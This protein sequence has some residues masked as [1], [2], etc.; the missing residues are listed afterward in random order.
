MSA[1][2]TTSAGAPDRG[3]KTRRPL[4]RATVFLARGLGLLL[5]FCALALGGG[6]F[7]LRTP[8]AEKFLLDKTAEALAA[9]GFIFTA[10]R[11][12]GPLPQRLALEDVSLADARGPILKAARAEVRWNMA[13]LLSGTVLV[14]IVE[15]DR[16]EMFRLPAPSPD[17][18]KEPPDSSRPFSPPVTIRLNALRLQGGRLHAAVLR[19]EAGPEG[20]V[21]ALTASGSAAVSSG[22]LAATLRC[23]ARL[24]EN[25][26]LSLDLRLVQGAA[27]QQPD[28][29]QHS[30]GS[31][32]PD[33]SQLHGGPERSDDSQ[34]PGN[35]QRP[36]GS[37]R[38]GGPEDTLVL[39]LAGDEAPGGILALVLD[40]PDLPAYSLRLNGSGGLK[41][42]RARLSLLA[43]KGETPLARSGARTDEPAEP[44]V[45]PDILDLSADLRLRCATGSLL[46]DV[47]VK[48]AFNLSLTARA[49][50]GE[51]I[52]PSLLPL[53]KGD[54]RADLEF[55]AAGTRYDL[56]AEA[57][58][59]AWSMRIS[60]AEIRPD[61]KTGL[62]TIKAAFQAV[63]SDPA[64]FTGGSGTAAS[65]KA[66]SD[67]NASGGNTHG[68]SADAG[69]SGGGANTNADGNTYGANA[70]A[71]GS[72]EAGSR[73]A[74]PLQ[75]AALTAA[76]EGSLG[77]DQSDLTL[78]GTLEAQTRER[79]FV[80]PCTLEAEVRERHFSLRR[81]SASGLGIRAEAAADFYA[82]SGAARATADIVADDKAEWQ[83]LVARLAGFTGP[84]SAETRT[85]EQQDAHAAA[86]GGELRLQASLNL[87]G[88]APAGE[89]TD[90]NPEKDT[91][92]AGKTNGKEPPA[93][94]NAGNNGA[95]DSAAGNNETV[96][97]AA[98]DKSRTSGTVATGNDRTGGSAG[99]ST[100]AD[101]ASPG[102]EM[103]AATPGIPPGSGLLRLTGSGM[104]WPTAQ[105]AGMLGPSLEVSARLKT[106]ENGANAW[107]VVLEEARAGIF[108]ASGKAVFTPP[109]G[110]TTASGPAREKSAPAHGASPRQTND[111]AGRQASDNTGGQTDSAP[112]P[113]TDDAARRQAEDKTGSAPDP[114]KGSAPPVPGAD[115]K[116]S[117]PAATGR[118]EA[119]LKAGISDLAPLGAGLAGVLKA[120]VNAS[121][122]LDALDLRVEADS[123]ALSTPNGVFHGLALR[124]DA[125]GTM[126]P[127]AS[128]VRRADAA[129]GSAIGAGQSAA[130]GPPASGPAGANTPPAGNVQPAA[131]LPPVGK[132]PA[133]AGNPADEAGGDL[134]LKG[135]LVLTAADSPG[136]PLS[137][138]GSWRAKAPAG[139]G[140][141]SASLNDFLAQ[142]AGVR[143]S[144]S[145]DGEIPR[146]APPASDPANGRG[147]APT[148]RTPPP[149]L[150]GEVNLDVNRWDRLAALTGAPLSGGPARARLRLDNA[151]GGQSASLDLTLQSLA[152]ENAA[153]GQ[154][155]FSLEGASASLVLPRFNPSASLTDLAPDFRLR[156][157]R[158]LAGPLQW[159]GG[160]ATVN[161]RAGAGEFA[162][163]LRRAASSGRAEQGGTPAAPAPAGRAKQG[164]AS[165]GPAPA[166]A[167]PADLLDVRGRY[168]L[169]RQEAVLTA[170]SL[171]VPA[172][173][174]VNGPGPAGPEAGVR[175]QQPLTVNFANG[176]R[177]IGLDLA[178]LPG[179]R[180][181]ADASLVRGLIRLKADLQALPFSFFALFT[182]TPLPEGKLWLT[183]DITSSAQ[184][185]RGAI[186]L[187][188]RINP[189]RSQLGLVRKKGP[190]HGPD[191]AARRPVKASPGKAALRS[192]PAL[193]GRPGSAN[194]PGNAS[195]PGSVNAS[196]SAGVPGSAAG[197]PGQDGAPAPA[198]AFDLR[199]TANLAASP[200]PG[201]APGSGVR[202]LAGHIWLNGSGSFGRA[203][204]D[205]KEGR[206]AF[207]IP[208]RL[209]PGG[210][211]LPNSRAPMAAS[212]HWDGAIEYLWQVV[213]LPDRHL[214][215]NALLDLAVTGSVDAPRPA[216]T[217]YLG[218]GRYEDID[219]G[220]LLTDIKLESRL[221]P[222]GNLNALLSAGDGQNG[223][224]AL[225]AVLRGLMGK[226]APLLAVRGQLDNL[227]PLQR[228]DLSISLSGIFGVRGSA[229]APAVTADI[230]VN[231]GEF[232]LASAM[233][234]SVATLDISP[235]PLD[236][237]GKNVTEN[238]KTAGT[239]NSGTKAGAAKSPSSAGPAR[240][241]GEK[242]A[243]SKDN[244][245]QGK[246]ASAG[247]PAA[248]KAAGPAK[249]KALSPAAGPSL[250]ARI[251]L[252]RQFFIRGRGL[253][254]EWEGELR[255]N[256]PVSD[257]SLTGAL[258]PVRG[259]FNILS[260]T[261][262]F[263]GGDI[264]FTG[265]M[266]INPLLNLE[267]TY[268]GPSI[269]AIVRVTGSAQKPQLG[270][271]SRPP[272][273]RD[274]ILAQ[275]LFGRRISQLSRFEALQLANSL[276]EL[277]NA[278]DSGLDVLGSVRRT[279]GLDVL[280]VG[281]RD[282]ADQ[283]TTSGQS[284]DS[285]LSGQRTQ[286]DDSASAPTLEAGKYINDSIYVG[287]EQGA[288]PD[289]TAVRVEVEL[290]PSV[291]LK[292]QSSATATEIGVGWKKDY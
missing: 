26:G 282:R 274:E 12:S 129:G 119:E 94:E 93:N 100:A 203:S 280:R 208:L 45:R 113:Q 188:S 43:G 46:N 232:N 110:E 155:A 209:S 38:S 84:A 4:R 205:P 197:P 184:G 180:L 1:V 131:N 217:A 151:G 161:G 292:G 172:R 76:L 211:P 271:E 153:T 238:G 265:G 48:P 191:S 278:G 144:A 250:D 279:V 222:D 53:L 138:S 175:L 286:Q 133:A 239:E 73:V 186:T 31:Q 123:P 89:D 112:G 58:A 98:A 260:R 214:S 19:P 190:A 230:Q 264:S 51:N 70:K 59:A 6:L 206:L 145:L 226:K 215:G 218:Q 29:P 290:F 201:A 194:A 111:A 164:R 87:P 47:A 143:I 95:V 78:N 176:P 15:L 212:V 204:A 258:R 71:G 259:Q 266:R 244:V 207:Q 276:R 146:S 179:G 243:S 136:G 40:K 269:T 170:L 289:S 116:D 229:D 52:P 88:H 273:P 219:A 281:S 62:R 196:G 69:G 2:T 255:I 156:L 80:I 108:S 251:T 33:G 36:G 5:L 24:P 182:D 125:H 288:T 178:F 20:P 49:R 83:T 275:V 14:E 79:A 150:K 231:Q 124:L 152:L 68:A 107:T 240:P 28:G 135:K 268:E 270:L 185:P 13:A 18:P 154:T 202:P 141:I 130:A 137:L 277:S 32:Q 147:K 99:K 248:A 227:S 50:P 7:W 283:R 198:D 63:L 291:N 167:G 35:A 189:A 157:G 120:T 253:D 252:P 199:I 96:D 134:A 160:T 163:S 65:D 262:T 287:V 245:A 173:S 109:A 142:G 67:K 237:A 241:E 16:P 10:A 159:S 117:Y 242:P 81:L 115:G 236:A 139:G 56:K 166:G 158:G 247:K 195:A 127:G 225:E 121:G 90:G 104:R 183:A 272:L 254:S 37:R 284:G 177:F 25:G 140:A 101:K 92:P 216:L 105:L 285:D 85:E 55:S 220:V 257:P 224:L 168:N 42:W 193:A 97:S 149:S 192:G 57:G 256:G 60:K 187:Q 174:F 17:K 41:D 3:K 132:A 263:T 171:R 261:F 8:T 23:E 246:G 22:G 30:G 165:A 162:L 75:S 11:L 148:G 34:Q 64:A 54:G 91:L 181:S 200:G 77:P 234:G 74:G 102:R 249:A 103:P 128:G 27:P 122:P 21:I 235:G 44:A 118:L 233:S 86:L 39:N 126:T 169:A 66:A 267:M 210:A 221:T 72:G 61:G 223:T 228:D 9:Q 106:G 82:D 114:A 213:P